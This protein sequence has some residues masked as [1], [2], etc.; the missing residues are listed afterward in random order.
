MALTFRPVRVRAGRLGRRCVE[1]RIRCGVM[2]IH[3]T[4]FRSSNSFRCAL[5]AAGIIATTAVLSLP[6][7]ETQHGTVR[8]EH[9]A[10]TILGENRT[11]LNPNRAIK[12]YLPPGYAD[13][14]KA[15]PVV[16]YLHNTFWNPEKMF[17]DGNLVRLL[18]RAFATGVVK[19][20]IFV[21]ADYST[22]T[23]G[24]L[25]E[26]SPVSG[27]WLDFTVDELVPFVDGTFRT[28]PHRESRAVV[29]DF[30]GGRGALKLAMVHAEIFSVA[31]ALHPVATGTGPIPWPEVQID[32]PKLHAAKTFEELGNDGRTRLFLV[33][34]QA[35]LPNVNRPPFYCDFFMEL[36]NGVPK[37]NVENT[38]KTKKGFLL[39]ETLVE[40]AV[41][42]RS[43]RGLAFDWARFDQT[44][45]H[46]YANRAFSRKLEDLGIAHEAEEYAGNPWNRNWTENGRFA[47]R[48]LPFLQR[49][50]VFDDQR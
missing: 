29:G 13:S 31:Y 42:L 8:T 44:Q 36:E 41:N 17:E 45:D 6:A 20:F 48:V 27:R 47:A 33:I 9:L 50:L 25:Y 23:T 10:S 43:M 14:G 28:L 39:E 12:V 11:A 16:Y 19:E 5:L 40:S 24:S 15:Y 1:G 37:L 7:A 30:F 3:P 21:A 35:F 4:L 22:S 34:S 49:H 46:V 18:E 38:L 32:W 26:N 2:K